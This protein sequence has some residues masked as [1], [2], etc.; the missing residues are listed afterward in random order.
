MGDP[1]RFMIWERYLGP[2]ASD[3]N[4]DDV[5][6]IRYWQMNYFPMYSHLDGLLVGV[7]LAGINLFRV[8]LDRRSNHPCASA[9]HLKK[10]PNG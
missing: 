3:P 6:G 1:I 10:N 9:C 5:F 8:R 4:S 7:V 2:I